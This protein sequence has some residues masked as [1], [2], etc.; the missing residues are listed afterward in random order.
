MASL[1]NQPSVI[2]AA[3]P[4][5]KSLRFWIGARADSLRVFAV[6]PWQAAP[7][8]SH[9]QKVSF[10]RAFFE[11]SSVRFFPISRICLSFQ[12][13]LRMV[14][15]GA[16]DFRGSKSLPRPPMFWGLLQSPAARGHAHESRW[17]CTRG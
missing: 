16:Q 10:A 11:R 2:S 12:P 8:L 15:I 4:P 1:V 14:S 9:L 7:Y 6:S 5:A 13:L 3:S 17:R